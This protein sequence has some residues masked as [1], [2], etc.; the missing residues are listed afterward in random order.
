MR[1]EIIS[2]WN[3]AAGSEKKKKERIKKKQQQKKTNNPA[4]EAVRVIRNGV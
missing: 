2:L 3:R 4:G 1:Y